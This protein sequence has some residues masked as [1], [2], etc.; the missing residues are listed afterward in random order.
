[1]VAENQEKSFI[2]AVY[3]IVEQTLHTECVFVGT[4]L[5]HAHLFAEALEIFMEASLYAHVQVFDVFLSF[6]HNATSH[7]HLLEQVLFILFHW[8]NL[9]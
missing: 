6:S 5:A 8:S 2:S 3:R 9:R 4:G 7:K 1:M